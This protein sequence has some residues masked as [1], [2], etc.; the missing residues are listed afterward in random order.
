MAD[1]RFAF[2]IFILMP[3]QTLFAHNYLTMPLYVK[4]AYAGTWLGENFEVAVNLNPLLI[5]I[6]V[7]IV[8]A[9]TRKTDIYRLMVVGTTIMAAPTFLLAFGP[10][11]PML[12]AYIFIMTIG[13]AIWQPRFLQY[14]AE[15][16]PEDKMGAYLGVARLPWFLT[17]MVTGLYA[18][19]FLMQYVPEEGVLQTGTMWFW[20]GVIAIITPIALLLA[21]RWMRSSFEPTTEQPPEETA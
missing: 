7:P 19:W 1:P 10:S 8:A 2:F 3:V 20:H 12:V 18:G 4:R 9:L 17:K 21:T 5:F 6:L 13:E 15:T 16:A 11:V 14:V